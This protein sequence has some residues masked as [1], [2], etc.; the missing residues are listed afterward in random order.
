MGVRDVHWQAV[1]WC[2]LIVS[3]LAFLPS[4]GVA[5]IETL[6][7]PGK[8]IAAHAKLEADC[9]NCHD[10]SDRNRQASLC[11][12]CHKSIDED[13]RTGHGFHGRL[14]GKER[15]QCRGCHT[16]HQGRDA[17]IVRLVPEQFDH[18]R[19]DFVLQDSHATLACGS[20]H[21]AGKPFRDMPTDCNGCHRNDQPHEG[22]LGTDCSS[23][24]DSRTWSHV[25]FDHDNTLFAL[26]GKHTGVAC[27]ACHIAN[28]YKGTPRQCDSCHAPDDVHR[29]ARGN[30]C[31]KCHTT[32][33]WATQKFDHARETGF[34][35]TAAHARTDCATCHTSGR[36]QDPIPKDC[37]GC[38]K[39]QDAHAGRLGTQCSNCHDNERWSQ[40]TFDHVRDAHFELSG[41]HA[42]ADCH[43]CHTANVAVQKLS[44]NCV[45]CHRGVDVH[46]GR[47]G[48]QCDSCHVPV[49]WRVDVRFD[50]DLTDFPLLGQ[51]VAVTC[52]QCHLKPTYKDTASGCV[53]CH[54]AADKHGGSLGPK[55]DSC[56]VPNGWNIWQFDHERAT[57]FALSGGHAKL[58]CANCH[59]RP[60]TQVKLAR[61]CG[62]CHA[63]DDVHFGEFG[64]QC[65]RCHST[66][67]FRQ[68]RI[69]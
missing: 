13:V 53:D 5:Q 64:R 4:A 31:N 7:M 36:M 8:V 32:T 67:S 19:T 50:H 66:I 9:A 43:A 24:H 37:H 38:H 62:A 25:K 34:A 28:R 47:L 3:L 48:M 21:V 12:G 1:P 14:I 54:R 2:T 69:R 15:I 6:L 33:R 29:G 51:H 42:K 40:S 68:V 45:S 58:E 22:K 56:H 26:T 63:K 20:C 18:S 39:A 61:E 23:C 55:C 30:D 10:R 35:L 17:D 27:V 59:R 44:R 52:E 65:Q 46:A 60:P 11:A 49:G 41:A 57:G 16:E